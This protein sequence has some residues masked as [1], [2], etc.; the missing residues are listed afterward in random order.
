MTRVKICGITNL[1]DAELAV[2][3]GADAIGFV[4]AESPRKISV[5]TAA[6]ISKALG[7]L[8]TTVGVFVNESPERMRRIAEECGLNALQLHG[9]ETPGVLGRLKGLKLIKAVRV[10]SG[11]RAATMKGYHPA[12]F[13]F[14]TRSK[15]KY[16]GTGKV[17]DWNLLSGL[18][19]KVP[20]I[21]SGGLNPDNVGEAVRRIRP[22]AVDVSG[23][24]EASPGKKSA[25]LLKEF[26]RNA[27][28]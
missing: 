14:D 25:R 4:F 16:G 18:Q 13:L 23:G 6:R 2:S 8:V 11:F 22:Y 7:P 10:G 9:D 1:R 3:L 27:K 24:V 20:M 15:G 28:A 17:F 19:L 5:Q 21:L 26:I 12:A